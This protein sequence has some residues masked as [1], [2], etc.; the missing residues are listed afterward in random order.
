MGDTTHCNVPIHYSRK[1]KGIRTM[2]DRYDL[3]AFIISLTSAF[4]IGFI[5]GSETLT[6]G[7][8]VG[9]TT[10]ICIRLLEYL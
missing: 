3:W 1:R 2:V 6:I 7:I 4:V 5:M 10:Y 8:V 9:L